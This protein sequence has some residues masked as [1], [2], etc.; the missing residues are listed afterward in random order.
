VHLEAILDAVDSGVAG[1][2]PVVSLDVTQAVAADAAI[3]VPSK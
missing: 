3:P 1:D 2:G